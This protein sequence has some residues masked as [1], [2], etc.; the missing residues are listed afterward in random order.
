MA[1]RPWLTLGVVFAAALLSLSCITPCFSGLT[2]SRPPADTSTPQPTVP[3]SQNAADRFAEKA[4][5]LH[6][7]TFSIEFTDE[8][9]TSYLALHALGSGPLASPQ[10]TF[11]PGRVAVTGELTTPIR[12]Q[13]TLSGTVRVAG[14]KLQF[15]FDAASIGN[16]DI[17]DAALDS[18]SD[19]ASQLI[20]DADTQVVLDSVE[21]LEGLIRITG[22]RAAG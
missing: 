10:V 15:S 11:H 16:V 22:H 6:H 8:E 7:D 21:V 17:P 18:V 14:G 20:I 13:V 12:G 1:Q 9:V 2:A 4:G 19:S 3:V 5:A